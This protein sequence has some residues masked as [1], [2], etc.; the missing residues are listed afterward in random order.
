MIARVQG[1]LGRLSGLLRRLLSPV[2]PAQ[3]VHKSFPPPRHA[4]PPAGVPPRLQTFSDP[5]PRAGGGLRCTS[6]HLSYSR[7]LVNGKR[8]WSFMRLGGR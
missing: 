7:H 4:A 6:V 8:V 1:R 2:L 3:P 5:A